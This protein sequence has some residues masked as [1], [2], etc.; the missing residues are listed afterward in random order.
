MILQD[1]VPEATYPRTA[2]QGVNPYHVAL[3]VRLQDDAADERVLRLQRLAQVVVPHVP[4]IERGNRS[5]APAP[6][7]A[8]GPVARS[9]VESKRRQWR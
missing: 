6:L 3:P 8:R 9:T 7:R 4:R 5:N 2:G 1:T